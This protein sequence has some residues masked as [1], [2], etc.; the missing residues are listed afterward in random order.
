LIWDTGEVTQ[1][2]L[3]AK[4]ATTKDQLI[5]TMVHS[6]KQ[7]V[8]NNK[9]LY[10]ELK[11]LVINGLGWNFIKQHDKMKD[12]HKAV[13]WTGGK[14]DEEDK[15]L[16]LQ[17]ISHFIVDLAMVLPL[18]VMSTCFCLVGKE[19]SVVKGQNY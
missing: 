12:G 5:A 17:L 7:F 6:G 18:T 3:G 14:T 4:Y 16:M 1:E 11:P 15:K 19:G 13:L 9:T 10:D 8:I 2:I